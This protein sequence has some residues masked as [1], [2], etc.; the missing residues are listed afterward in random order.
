MT[1]DLQCPYCDE[2]QEI[3]HDDGYG[4]GEDEVYQ[5]TCSDCHKTFTYTTSI[6]YF[7]EAQKADCLN[8]G[9]HDWQITHTH[10]KKYS[11]MCCTMCDERR[12][13]TPEERE[14]Y[15]LDSD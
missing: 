4:Y 10:P 13:P 2:W 12:K 3:D 14:K 9:E 7:H 11:E 1:K 5:Q 15:K 8:D 6:I